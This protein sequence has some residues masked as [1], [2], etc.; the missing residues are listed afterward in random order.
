MSSKKRNTTFLI[1]R[2]TIGMKFECQLSV[3]IFD[4][5]FRCIFFHSKNF[6]V[7]DRS[8]FSTHLLLLLPCNAINKQ[9]LF[10]SN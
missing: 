3:A 4:L 7:I 10:L 6:I 2:I 9:I 5:L 1:T 8:V